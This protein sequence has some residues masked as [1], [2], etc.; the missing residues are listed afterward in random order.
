MESPAA[1]ERGREDLGSG[2][3]CGRAG[4][5]VRALRGPAAA[6]PR[7]SPVEGTVCHRDK[8]TCVS[9]GAQGDLESFPWG[10][11]PG[12]RAEATAAVQRPRPR[13]VKPH[14]RWPRTGNAPSR[15]VKAKAWSREAPEGLPALSLCIS[16][17][18]PHF[19][20]SLYSAS[21]SPTTDGLSPSLS[22]AVGSA[23]P[24][25][26][27]SPACVGGERNP[28]SLWPRSGHRSI[29]GP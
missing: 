16:P 28:D 10:Q 4:W 18:R 24:E 25:G 13:R 2:P 27:A 21:L 8:H 22:P 23:A 7:S 6:S 26:G 20:A 12:P 19:V 15:G 1:S 5:G 14:S 3:R 11:P 9:S 29:S 17:W